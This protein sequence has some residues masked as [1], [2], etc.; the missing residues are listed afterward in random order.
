MVLCVPLPGAAVPLV[1]GVE[2]LTG[3]VRVGWDVWPVC[4][5]YLM[6]C[7]VFRQEYISKFRATV[8]EGR[9]QT[10]RVL[11]SWWRYVR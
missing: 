3:S 1:P 4:K 9:R 2:V 8:N 10:N 7:T 5:G 6:G 11:V